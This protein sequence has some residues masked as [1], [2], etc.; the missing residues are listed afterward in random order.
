[1]SITYPDGYNDL[2]SIRK[3]LVTL[4]DDTPLITATGVQFRG[5]P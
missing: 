5:T 4:Q 1:M 3:M 2:T